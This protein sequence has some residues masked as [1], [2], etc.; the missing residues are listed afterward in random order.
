MKEDRE[1]TVFMIHIE[2]KSVD[3]PDCLNN[4]YV[5]S[6]VTTITMSK[7]MRVSPCCHSLVSWGLLLSLSCGLLESLSDSG[8]CRGGRSVPDSLVLEHVG[9]EL[10]LGLGQAGPRGSVVAVDLQWVILLN[11]LF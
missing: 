8:S 7:S 1:I 2:M 9:G 4:K 6:L 3:N 11:C 5:L 10:C